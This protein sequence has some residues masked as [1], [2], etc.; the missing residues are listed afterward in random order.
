MLKTG[1]RIETQHKVGRLLHITLFGEFDGRCAWELFKTI[2][3]Q[4]AASN[5]IFVNTI[6]L[7]RVRSSGVKLFRLHMAYKKMSSDWLYFKGRK[8]FK[9]APNGSRVLV[10]KKKPS[11]TSP[12]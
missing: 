1:Y 9:L 4:G 7:K 11:A 8:G 10:K 2:K 6:G 5:R 3:W 12:I